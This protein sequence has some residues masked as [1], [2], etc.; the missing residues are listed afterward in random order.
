M[1]WI[2]YEINVLTALSTFQY[3]NDPEGIAFFI[4][5]EYDYCIKR[6]GDMIYGVPV[7]NGNVTGMAKVITD[8]FKK[9]KESGEENFNIL[10]EIYPSAF[11]AY[12]LGA[13]MAPLPNPLLRPGGWQSTPPA[14]GTIMNIGPEPM[15]LISSAAVNKALK[16]AAKQL[17]DDLKSVTI[18]I[19]GIGEINVY[20][21]VLKIL[22]KEKVDSK[23]KN[24]PIIIAGK[25]V[26]LN[27]QEIKKKLPSIGS[28]IKKAIKFPFP[29]LP[30]KKKIIEE[31]K[32]KLIEEAIKQLEETI[33][34]PIEDVI[35]TPIYAAIQT[36]VDTAN[37]LPKKPTKE[38]I[39]KFVKDTIA[40]LVPDIALPGISIPHIPTKKELKAMIKEKTPTKEQLEAMAYD[41]IKGL[42]PK[43]PNIWFIPPTLL[44]TIPTNIFLNPF[45]NLAK[46]H[47][48]GVSGTMMVLAQYPPP[49]PPAPALINWTGYNVIG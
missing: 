24:H 42:I 46:F 32:K 29:E 13:E 4:A 14:P 10:D 40:G 37:H 1:S 22:K 6:G 15:K 17:V 16:E 47:L 30:K 36:A 25:K 38:E 5:K 27:Y 3:T 39:K 7:L 8:A 21:T 18:L 20:E 33:I 23:I 43:I 35:L 31:A 44:F 28:Q 34:K 19:E 9:G 2:I 45:V 12:W 49:A 41:M 11:D 26:V 48:M